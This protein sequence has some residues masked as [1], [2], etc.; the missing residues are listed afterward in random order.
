MVCATRCD[1]PPIP[2]ALPCACVR[3]GLHGV[4][5]LKLVMW[6]FWLAL[7]KYLDMLHGQAREKDP[8]SPEI[9]SHFLVTQEAQASRKEREIEQ[10]IAS[11]ATVEVLTSL[12]ISIV[13]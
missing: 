8:N 1:P 3:L 13:L 4:T 12:G 2:F 7:A 5:I 6:Q 9:A 10:T 11:E